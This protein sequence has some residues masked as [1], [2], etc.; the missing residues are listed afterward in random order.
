MIRLNRSSTRS[1]RL[2]RLVGLVSTLVALQGCAGYTFTPNGSYQTFSDS[3]GGSNFQPQAR[4][5]NCVSRP[6]YV[7]GEYVRTDTVCR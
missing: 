5:T 2:V 1:C 6:V 4:Q 7:L 3:M